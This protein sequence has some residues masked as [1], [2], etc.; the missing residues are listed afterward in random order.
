MEV[1]KVED[2]HLT[3]QIGSQLRSL[4][5]MFDNCILNP[6]TVPLEE[7]ER[8]V[9]TDETVAI[10]IQF[11]VSSVLLKLG[12]YRHENK[13]ITDFVNDNFES[14]QGNILT[15][16]EDILSALWAGYS[17]TEIVWKPS[18]SQI[19]IDR[20]ATYHPRTIY[21]KVDT[22]TG[23]YQGFKQWRWFAGSPVDIPPEKAIFYA[24][25]MRF[26]NWYGRSILKPIRKNWLLKDPVLKMWARALDRFG[27]PLVAAFVPDEIIDDPDNPSNQINQMEWANRQLKNMQNGTGFVFRSDTKGSAY[28][29][30]VEAITNGGSGIGESFDRAVQYFNKMLLRGMLVPSLIFDEGLSGSYSLGQNHFSV[31]N[32]GVSNIYNRFTETI[33]EQLVKRMVDLNFGPQKDYGSFVENE[34][35]SED[36]KLL[37]D[38][39]TQLTNTGYMDPQI[40]EDFDAV[41]EKLGLPQR[42]VVTTDDKMATISE[43]AYTRYT[44][45]DIGDPNAQENDERSNAKG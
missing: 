12:E 34:I 45:G 38:G 6:E 32:L 18:G 35:E 43:N 29:T 42:K 40:Q 7:F 13:K 24:H 30:K 21:I 22:Q 31:F 11:L 39:F 8:M 2:N 25:N 5:F 27:T 14:M 37:F 10:G 28:E 20:L 1:I 17:G 3:G 23:E 4:F 15:A 16:A 36:T 9:D 44:S 19:V 41:R 33:I 26:G